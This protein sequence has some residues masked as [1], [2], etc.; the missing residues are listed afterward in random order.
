MAH[1]LSPPHILESVST[2]QI[3]LINI[4][5]NMV[6]LNPTVLLAQY[7]L[8]VADHTSSIASAARRPYAIRLAGESDVDQLVHIEQVCWGTLHLSAER[9]LSRIRNH[10]A[11]Q[12][13]C[14]VDEMVVGV[15][16]TQNLTE[17]EVLLQ[18]GV[19]F[20]NQEQL[21][22]A[23]GSRVIQ[24]LGVAVLPEYA[25]LQ[26]GSGLRNFVLQLAHL[27]AEITTVVAMTR[28][29]S[30]T[31]AS[32]KS[33]TAVL[34]EYNKKALAGADPTLT[35][36]TS[37]GAT[38]VAT[39]PNYRPEDTIN[40]GHAVFIKYIIKSVVAE[41]DPVKSGSTNVASDAPS[42]PTSSLIS[43]AELR[44]LLLECLETADS[45]QA[46]KNMSE[47]TFLDAP[48]MNLGLHSLAMVDMQNKLAQFLSTK[49]VSDSSDKLKI[50]HTLL[51][52]FPTP[53]AL[54]F[55]LNGSLLGH[56][57]PALKTP[58]AHADTSN[59]VQFAICGM[60]CRL[61]GDINTPDAFHAALLGGADTVTT[62]PVEW[63]WDAKTR[64]ASLLSETAAETFDAAFFKLN[65]AEAQHMDPHQRII[66]EVG[67]EALV[68][69][70][71]LQ[72]KDGGDRVGVFVGLCNNEWK[73]SNASELGPYHTTGSAQS[74]TANRVSF[75][76]GL[77]GPSMVV[78]TACSS[79]LAA[80]HTAMNALRCGDCD[81]ALVAAADLLV[82]ASSLKVGQ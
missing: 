73:H 49:T 30:A 51:F 23:N 27:S 29:S 77:T 19:N 6:E 71:V 69:A 37:G 24:L 2:P 79:S 21:H 62:V 72:Q 74:A 76:L 9:V 14:T 66:L 43:T 1:S 54:L 56:E 32:W 36:H 59:P 68:S 48:F 33:D 15:M 20:H 60:S 40:L 28:C 57:E 25:H 63:G 52:D 65:A 61:P 5:Y 75:L 31:D 45:T 67:H 10:S 18:E 3:E 12:W 47:E 17:P 8:F 50:S 22:V 7:G 26:I 46:A 58:S 41:N 78:D 64:R 80:L 13:V 70:Q 44:A 53:R 4:C 39:V 38:V 81:V 82:S 11:G 16:Y 55:E 42:N 35:F 34:A